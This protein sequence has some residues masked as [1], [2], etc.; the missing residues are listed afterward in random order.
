MRR[1]LTTVPPIFLLGL[2]LVNRTQLSAQ[3]R[4]HDA[5]RESI[6]QDA[7]KAAETI[8]SGSLFKKQAQNL[9]LLVE[10]DV[11]TTVADARIAMLG[12]VNALH[13]W[14]DVKDLS[15]GVAGLAVPETPSDLEERKANLAKSKSEL[16]DQITSLSAV[17]VKDNDGL[18]PLVNTIGN[19]DSA[20]TFADK[21]LG[22]DDDNL[23]TAIGVLDRLQNLYKNYQLQFQVVNDAAKGLSD[24][25]IGMKKALLARLKVEE[26][27]LV[28]EIGL[29][30]RKEMELAAVE[31]WRKRCRIP[32]GIP[33]EEFIDTTLDRLAS[34]DREELDRAVRA[35][36]ACGALSAEA[37]L[38]LNLFK[39]RM[40]QLQHL[41][42]IQI[43]AANA[44]IYES[45]LGGG[46]ERL[47]LFYKGGVK[48]E[49]V[50][51]LLQSLSTVGIFGKFLTQ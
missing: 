33:P 12:M 43:S 50:A 18:Q 39:L 47:A 27:A 21:H 23:T 42:S 14:S 45:V 9:Q 25:K 17:A 29:H 4:M 30:S 35:L 1:P 41:K 8:K 34:G 3:L 19:I 40:A 48:P 6:A 11:T 10:R 28:A 36:Y 49:T 16:K 31:H 26:N 22:V 51:Q 13:Q 38:P 2:L 37:L 32:K 46:V 15:E 24:L 7:K 5:Q 44:K 20:L